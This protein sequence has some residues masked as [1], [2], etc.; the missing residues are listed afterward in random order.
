MPKIEITTGENT[1]YEAEAY[2]K[3]AEMAKN[4]MDNLEAERDKAVAES[5]ALLQKLDELSEAFMHLKADNEML[6]KSNESFR[7]TVCDLKEEYKRLACT[8]TCDECGDAEDAEDD[9]DD[10]DA[11]GFLTIETD[12]DTLGTI[13]EMDAEICNLDGQIEA[14]QY[15]IHAMCSWIK[16]GEPEMIKLLRNTQESIETTEKP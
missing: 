7:K 12:E 2:R 10:D 13:A 8:H 6:R 4:R 16:D 11:P 5:K 9:E 3:A 15:V 14:Y 1:N